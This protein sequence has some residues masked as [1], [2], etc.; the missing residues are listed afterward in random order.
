M[1]CVLS[2]PTA[3]QIKVERLF[4]CHVWRN[5]CSQTSS[6]AEALRYSQ[7][8]TNAH[9]SAPTRHKLWG[10]CSFFC[11]LESETS[12]QQ[13]IIVPTD[14]LQNHLDDSEKS[15]VKYLQVRR[16]F[17]TFYRSKPLSS[18]QTTHKKQQSTTTCL[19]A[20]SI[21]DSKSVLAWM[22]RRE[23]VGQSVS[24]TTS[25]GVMMETPRRC[26][27]ESEEDGGE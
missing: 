27:N 4:L 21:N 24:Q 13:R 6:D 9:S 15:S 5:W 7:M 18:L 3:N 10:S 14:T 2:S 20:D 16:M 11:N 12:E 25:W 17:L 23:E 8:L 1:E 19:S 26:G 22:W